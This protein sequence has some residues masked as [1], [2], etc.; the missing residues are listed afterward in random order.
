MAYYAQAVAEVLEVPT[1]KIDYRL[2][3]EGGTYPENVMDVKCGVQWPPPF[4][5]RRRRRSPGRS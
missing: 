3:H 1:F 5:G 2:V 4:S